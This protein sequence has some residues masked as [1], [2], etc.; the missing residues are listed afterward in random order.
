MLAD[1]LLFID[2]D[3]VHHRDLACW[4]A[5]AEGRHTSPY[6]HSFRERT[7][8]P[9]AAFPTC[10]FVFARSVMVSSLSRTGRLGL[11]RYGADRCKGH[12][13]EFARD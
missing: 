5:E 9:S 13:S 12:G 1:P 3:A 10:K 8:S 6:F 11:R 7:T 2:N 4:A